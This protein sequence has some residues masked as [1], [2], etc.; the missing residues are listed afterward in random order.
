MKSLNIEYK[1]YLYRRTKMNGCAMLFWAVVLLVLYVLYMSNAAVYFPNAVS[2]GHALMGDTLAA[3]TRSLVI[4]PQEEAFDCVSYNVTTPPMLRLDETYRNGTYYRFKFIPDAVRETGIGYTRARDASR[5]LVM[6]DENGALPDVTEN[7]IMLV[8]IGGMEY[9][10]IVPMGYQ[11]TAGAL[12]QAAVFI[13]L[14]L[15][16]GHDLGLTDVAGET[17]GNWC[18]D[19]RGLS[20][21]DERG[22]FALIIVFSI[23]FPLFFI[24]ALMCIIKP[25]LHIN[26]ILLSKFVPDLEATCR[27]LDEEIA[28]EGVYKEGK[29]VYTEHYIIRETL[30]STRVTKNHTFRN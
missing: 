25:R 29:L 22:D 4:E 23:L 9:A 27:E 3:D 15:Y 24:Y 2:R 13:E 26:F 12:V 11:L 16:I 1:G 5:L 7:R 20:V 19:L 8:T 18:L 10:A 6:A 14:P 17:I 21:D 30:Y 28:Q